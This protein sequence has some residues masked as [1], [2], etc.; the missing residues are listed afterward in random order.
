MN[1]YKQ[2]LKNVGLLTIGNFTSKLLSFLLVPLYT[3]VLSTEEYGT[4]DLIVTTV[5]L[6]LPIL[7]VNIIEAVLRFPLDRQEE[8]GYV[9]DVYSVGLR[10]TL[11]SCGIMFAVLGINHAIDLF[12][13]LVKYE[14]YMFAYFVVQAFNQLL[15]SF[16]RATNHVKDVSIAGVL[17]SALMIGLNLLFLLYFRIG[18]IGYFLATI[19]SHAAA[20]I[21]YCIRLKIISFTK[22]KLSIPTITGEMIAY[23]FPM[24]FNT[25]GWWVNNASDRYVVTWFCGVSENGIYSVAYKLP[26]ILNVFHAIFTQA[27]ILSAVQEYKSDGNSKFFLTVYN[28]YGCLMTLLCSAL[29]VFTK[30]IAHLLFQKD[31]YIAWQYSPWL[32][33][34]VVFGALSGVIGG[35]FSAEKASNVFAISTCIGATI[36]VVLNLALVKPLG[37]L[38]AAIATAVSAY[39]VWIFRVKH[40]QKFIELNLNLFRDHFAYITLCLQ[41]VIGLLIR[42]EYICYLIN[43]SLFLLLI[44][45]YRK[46][47]ALMVTK[48]NRAI[49]YRDF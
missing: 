27:W 21:Y 24:I 29:I 26:S 6:L 15:M 42:R 47:L 20:D 45:V 17:S 14:I 23:S 25:V 11:I 7:S 18:L 16:A 38:G 44:F 37:P 9:S 8:K 19:I 49:K 1:R 40:S 34:A 39:V 5:S 4:F 10:L 22:T 3:H 2:L 12:P 48:L 43:A 36:N 28:T 32:L 31:F 41:G 35:V 46:E 33:I 13:S 30:P